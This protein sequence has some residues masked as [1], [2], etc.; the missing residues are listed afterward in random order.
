MDYGSLQAQKQRGILAKSRNNQL[1]EQIEHALFRINQ[2]EFGYCEM[3]G[4]EIG[5]AAHFQ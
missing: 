1:I 2:G 4:E 5:Q 3:T